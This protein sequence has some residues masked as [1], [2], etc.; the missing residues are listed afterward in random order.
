MEALAEPLVVRRLR[1][2]KD[3]VL[4]R[5]AETMRTMARRWLQ[6]ENALEAQI[7]ALAEQTAR[8]AAA[9]KTISLGRIYRLER[10]HRLL[11]QSQQ[12]FGKFA[13]WSDGVISAGQTQFAMM[14]IEHAN[15]ALGL[16]TTG[17]QWDRLNTDAV[18][19][20]IGMVGDGEP[21]GDLLNLRM[22]KDATGLPLPGVSE[23][24]AQTLVNAS[25]QG[26]NPRRTARMM[27]D[28]LAGGLDKALQIARTEQLRVYREAS[29][30]QYE[31]SG[32]VEGIARLCAHQKN[33]CLACL[34]DEGHVYP[35]SEGVPDHV[36]GRCAG[37][38]Q[39]IGVKPPKFQ[40]GEQWLATQ[41]E[42]TQRLVMGN[43]RYDAW[44]NGD[45]KFSDFAT[46]TQH[47]VWGGGLKVTPLA[48]LTGGN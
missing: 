46:P 5:E 6:V 21:L 3:D 37:V 32:V 28:N 8:E 39:L 26:W 29:R 1:E 13:A 14:G 4:T 12:E 34:A 33:T 45:V 20:M 30:T 25:A 35:V 19:N 47:E 31:A 42:E 38:P 43:T 36:Q 7:T 18:N 22:V 41:D 9:G 17:I 40:T 24:L 16:V 23:R 48:A 10:Y 27:R 2:F 44:K 15:E 11:A